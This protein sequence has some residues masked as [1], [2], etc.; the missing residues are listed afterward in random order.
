MHDVAETLSYLFANVL[1]NPND[2]ARRSHLHN[3]AVVRHTI[4]RGVNLWNLNVCGV[5]TSVLQ[6]YCIEF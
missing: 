4:K 2:V 5:H 3:L 1:P 6:D